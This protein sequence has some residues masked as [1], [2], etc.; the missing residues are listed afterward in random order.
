M[1]LM[2]SEKKAGRRWVVSPEDTR[3]FRAS[4]MIRYSGW[5]VVG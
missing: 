3:G 1:G 4:I 5:W 2:N